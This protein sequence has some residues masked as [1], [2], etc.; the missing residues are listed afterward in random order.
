MSVERLFCEETRRVDFVAAFNKGL[1]A[2]QIA[3]K[4]KHEIDSVFD[5]LNKQLAEVAH[6]RVKFE[7]KECLKNNDDGLLSGSRV[8]FR[9][10][11]YQALC[12]MNPLSPQSPAK[13]IATWRQNRMGYPCKISFGTKEHYCE[14]KFT[15]ENAL[16][17]MLQDPIVGENLAKLVALSEASA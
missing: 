17:L 14:D 15:L 8:A 12:A 10:M 5:E 7:R 13:E 3:E 6:G 4:N 9:D 2:A 11:K 1:D 16:A